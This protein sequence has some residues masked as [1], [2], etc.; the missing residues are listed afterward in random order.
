V[1]ASGDNLELIRRAFE[2]FNRRDFDAAL[3]LLDDSVT[4]KAAFPAGTAVVEGKAE[5]RAQWTSRVE[6]LDLRVEP[7]ELTPIDDYG[8]VAVA[9]WRGRGQISSTPVKQTGALAFLIHD[10]KV[11][12]VEGHASK[13]EALEAF[14]P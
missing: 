2:A 3:D 4:W 5:I 12:R 6:A 13:E 10:A 11:I 14:S 9:T 8:V 7:E 1:S